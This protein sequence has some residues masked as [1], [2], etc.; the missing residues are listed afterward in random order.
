MIRREAATY[1]AREIKAVCARIANDKG[2]LLHTW[3]TLGNHSETITVDTITES[4][5]KEAGK[6]LRQKIL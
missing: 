4:R 2:R 6:A 5:K 1:Q 3:D